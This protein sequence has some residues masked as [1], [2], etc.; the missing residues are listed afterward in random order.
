MG[1]IV[2]EIRG[3]NGAKHQYKGRAINIDDFG[4]GIMIEGRGEH[5]DHF[6][7]SHNN[8]QKYWYKGKWIYIATNKSSTLE[9][10]YENQ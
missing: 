8:I 3:R 10:A 9:A 2:V 7:V 4:I 5:E 6:W 1:I